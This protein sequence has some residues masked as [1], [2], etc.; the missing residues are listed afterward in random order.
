MACL[1]GSHSFTL[2]RIEQRRHNFCWCHRC[3]RRS[4]L[5][6]PHIHTTFFFVLIALRCLLILL[7][8]LCWYYYCTQFLILSSRITGDQT[9][10]TAE[11]KN[12]ELCSEHIERDREKEKDVPTRQNNNTPISRQTHAHTNIEFYLR[13]Q[14]VLNI[15]REKAV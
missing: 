9:T 10:C 7:S 11:H 14:N 8:A 6:L 3:R 2:Y 13:C 12:V 15:E 1:N 5:R 4:S